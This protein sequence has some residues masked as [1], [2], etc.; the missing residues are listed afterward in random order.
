MILKEDMH[1][2]DCEIKTFNSMPAE[3]R[4]I[5]K[6]VFVEEQGFTDEFDQTDQTAYHMVAFVDGEAA[7]T[8]RFFRNTET[9]YTVGR[10]AV[11][12]QYRGKHLGKRLLEAAEKAILE[13]GGHSVSLHSQLRAA[14]FYE[15]LSYVPFG[16]AD[17]EQGC[18]HIW[19][20]KAL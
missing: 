9:E 6:K 10:I 20:R 12:K 16:E 3:A 8:C 4:E 15:K 7:A 5:R 11:L 1:M 18:P 13:S 19:M 14:G 17:E 2:G